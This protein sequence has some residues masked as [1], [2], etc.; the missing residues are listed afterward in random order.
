MSKTSE[1]SLTSDHYIKMK[2]GYESIFLFP[3]EDGIQVMNAL[4]NSIIL[5]QK[6]RDPISLSNPTEMPEITVVTK[7]AIKET[8]AESL[9]KHKEHLAKELLKG[10]T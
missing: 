9:V 6:Y 4:K 8:I 7:E 5:N 10:N 1:P 2:F 3:Y